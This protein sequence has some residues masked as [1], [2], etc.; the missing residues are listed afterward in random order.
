MA[1]TQGQRVG[2]VVEGEA[3]GVAGAPRSLRAR[4]VPQP[5]RWDGEQVSVLEDGVEVRDG[6]ALADEDDEAGAFEPRQAVAKLARAPNLACGSR[7]SGAALVEMQGF[8]RWKDDE[9][10]HERTSSAARAT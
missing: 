3:C 8:G 2:A 9:Q 5:G 6:M 4:D 10:P 7:P 1:Q